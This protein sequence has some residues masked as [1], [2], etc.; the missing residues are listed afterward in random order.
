[1]DM[2]EAYLRAVSR[3]LPKAQREDVAAELRDEILT[4]IEAKEAE[5]GRALTPDETEALLRE[6]GH[7]ILVAARYRQEPQSVIGPALDPYWAFFVRLAILIEVFASAL[8][9]FSRIIGGADPTQAIGQ[10]IVSGLGGILTLIGLATAVAWVI[11]R[12]AIRIDY[13]DRWRVRDLRF[14]DFALWDWS[15]LGDMLSGQSGPAFARSGAGHQRWQPPYPGPRFYGWRQ[16]SAGRGIATIVFGAMF[17][18]WWTGLIHFGV[19]AQLF[20]QPNMNIDPGALARIDWPALKDLIYWPVIA[21][22]AMLPALPP[23]IYHRCPAIPSRYI[24]A[25]A[26][27]SPVPAGTEPACPHCPDQAARFRSRFSNRPVVPPA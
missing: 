24:S 10:A 1:M 16:S 23:P 8:V 2:L 26:L 15:D 12:K 5:Q 20:T 13:L 14:L 18:L 3:L 27:T 19:T 9:F 21:Y 25:P 17:I 11:E 7:P 22:F 6:I 4:R